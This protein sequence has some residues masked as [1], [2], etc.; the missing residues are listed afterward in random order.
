[1]YISKA[2]IIEK[3]IW[4]EIASKEQYT[5]KKIRFSQVKFPTNHELCKKEKHVSVV[6]KVL[7]QLRSWHHRKAFVHK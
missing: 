2:Q 7:C 5:R 6:T 1:M 4:E 3:S